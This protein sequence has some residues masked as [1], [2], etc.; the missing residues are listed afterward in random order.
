MR[1]DARSIVPW[2]RPRAGLPQ[3]ADRNRGGSSRAGKWPPRATEAAQEVASHANSD[4][5]RM[6]AAA[7]QR[8]AHAERVRWRS[9][10]L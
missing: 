2:R 3:A 8:S 9:R 10:R 1:K 7:S 6:P 4:S 5:P